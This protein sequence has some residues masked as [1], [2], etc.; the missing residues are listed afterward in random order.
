MQID[1]R[2]RRTSLDL[3]IHN[4]QVPSSVSFNNLPN[5]IFKGIKIK[6]HTTP[7]LKK[8]KWHARY[9]TVPLIAKFTSIMVKISIIFV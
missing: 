6:I 1:Q 4:T 8:I 5:G 2:S 3:D 9:T 7:H